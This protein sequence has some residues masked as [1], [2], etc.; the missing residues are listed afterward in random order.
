MTSQRWLGALGAVLLASCASY[1]APD[2]V[3]YGQAVIT[4][5][6][7]GFDFKPLGTY[8]LVPKYSEPRAGD[9][10]PTLV[11]IP[12]AVVTAIDSAMEGYGYTAATDPVTG[13]TPDV[14]LDMTVL[15]GTGQ[16]YYPGYW[17]DY[18]YYY[19]CYYD[20]YYAGSYTYGMAVLEMTDVRGAAAGDTVPVVWAAGVYGV[21][22]T[23]AYDTSRAVEGF[24]R[25]FNQSPY[26][27][28]H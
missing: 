13:G 10:P 7:P 26:L 21:A 14:V 15:T 23:A 22:T 24:S 2:S 12:A 6:K 27:D 1:G 28:T 17:C 5:P 18:Y 19:Y 20:W 9:L 3:I 11:D 16:V 25:A 4:A 8:Y